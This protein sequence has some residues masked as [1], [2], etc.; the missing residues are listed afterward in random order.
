MDML[1]NLKTFHEYNLDGSVDVAHRNALLS[2]GKKVRYV[3]T[4]DELRYTKAMT[5]DKS[6]TM[7]AQ[8]EDDFKHN[9]LHANFHTPL[10]WCKSHVPN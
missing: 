5:T 7:V 9:A 4:F 6:A 10:I 8:A 1:S 3:D 2:Y